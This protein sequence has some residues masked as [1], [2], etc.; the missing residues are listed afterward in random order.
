M[1]HEDELRTRMCLVLRSGACQRINF[2][3]AVSVTGFNYG[4]VADMVER[5]IIGMK[6]VDLGKKIEG[7]YS[8]I[9]NQKYRSD[10]DPDKMFLFRPE[11]WLVIRSGNPFSLGT[12]VHEATHALHDAVAK[13]RRI[14]W[15]DSEVTA[16]VAETIYLRNL[17]ID[18][19]WVRAANGDGY[20]EL[21]EKI[22]NYRGPSIYEC[23]A[24]DVRELRAKTEARYM[25]ED[26]EGRSRGATYR[27]IG[28]PWPDKP[29]IYR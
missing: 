7:K 24:D 20:Y 10:S 25:R 28:I 17:G 12:L 23:T 2:K 29:W 3:H 22:R 15:Q 19:N 6:E 5:Q 8:P 18:E 1:S 14:H 11:T 13:G 21:A 4:Y 16:F 9:L 27:S 26:P